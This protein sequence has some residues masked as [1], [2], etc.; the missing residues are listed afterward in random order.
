[1][2]HTINSSGPRGPFT[3]A[4][5]VLREERLH[6]YNLQWIQIIHTTRFQQR[7]IFAFWFLQQSLLQPQIAESILFTD[8]ATFMCNGVFDMHNNYVWA[9]VNPHITRSRGRQQRFSHT[10][11]E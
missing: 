3:T 7:V 4:W 1:M 2:K 8:K 6:F 10:F 9:A 11:S 5:H